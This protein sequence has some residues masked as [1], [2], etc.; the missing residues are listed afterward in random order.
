MTARKK[1]AVRTTR[2]AKRKRSRARATKPARER[3]GPKLERAAQRG[4]SSSRL[5][6][7]KRLRTDPHVDPAE[8]APRA[9][10]GRPETSGAWRVAQCLLT[11]LG[12]VDELAPKRSRRCDGT[13]GDAAHAART[14]DHNP[15]VIDG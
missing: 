11:L 15:W 6:A 2:S 7:T 5:K 9:A 8:P 10:K 1:R 3:T 14:S 13:I 4:P 12:Q